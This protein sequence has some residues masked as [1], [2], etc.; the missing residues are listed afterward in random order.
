MFGGTAFM[1]R[2][3]MLVAV[4]PRGLLVRVGPDAHDR[5][6]RTP[7]TQAMKMR[8]RVMQG[9]VF[10]DPPP[11]DAEAVR[12][13]LDGALA[14]NKTLPAKAAPSRSKTK[15]KTARASSRRKARS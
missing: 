8:G 6:L 5:A 13:W 14:H 9:Y 3:H 1:V 7:N 2:E 4:S 11:T 10:V 15:S 12:T